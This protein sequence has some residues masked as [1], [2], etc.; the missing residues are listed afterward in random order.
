MKKGSNAVSVT[1]SSLASDP[2]SGLVSES[3]PANAATPK[4][5]AVKSEVRLFKSDFLEQFTHVHPITPLVMWTPIVAYIYWRAFHTDGLSVFAI[6]GYSALGLVAWTLTEYIMH[7]FAFHFPA[8]SAAGKRFVYIMH[9]LHHD[10]PSDGTRL[11]MPPVP[12]LIYAAFLFWVYRA[13]LGPTA[14]LP[15]FAAFLIGYLAYDYIHYSV[16]HFVPKGAV[17]KYL[18]RH[19]MIHHF[20]DHDAKWGVSSPLWDYLLGTVE[21]RKPRETSAQRV[22]SK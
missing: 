3:A 4:A 1:N 9:G 2:A 11:V 21:M 13:L 10:D 18:K 6:L 5:A 12:G 22:A 14:V 7:R 8:K 17:G 16:H 19:H 15:F 20:R